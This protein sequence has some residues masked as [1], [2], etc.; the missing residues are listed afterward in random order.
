MAIKTYV[1]GQSQ[2]L[3]ENFDVIE[4]KC[5]GSGCCSRTLIDDQLVKYLQQIRDHF[6]RKVGINS[7]Y[8]CPTHNRNVK[9]GSKSYHIQGKAAD[10]V[11][12][13]VAPAEVAKYAESI[14]IL[15]IG[16]YETPRDGFF[17][18]ID[19]R[20]TKAFW[21]GQKQARRTTFG[22]SKI[23][24]QEEEEVTQEQFNK[25]MNTWLAEQAKKPASDWSAEA[26]EWAERNEFVKGDETGNKM[27]KKLLTREEMVTVLHRA[28]RRNI[29]E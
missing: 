3:S 13:G 18:H 23:S 2:K 16:L 28:F 24:K 19:T 14:G 27:Y 7:A 20:T 9:G 8:R 25:M 22:G 6:G 29:I 12:E 4:F 5:K 11:V 21:Y 17:V 26:R 1:K 10:I 15:G